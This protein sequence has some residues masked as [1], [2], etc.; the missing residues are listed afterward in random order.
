M[1]TTPMDRMHPAC[2]DRSPART[3]RPWPAR[4]TSAVAAGLLI[5][6]LALAA[7]SKAD[8]GSA[9]VGAAP[10]QAQGQAVSADSDTVELVDTA[11]TTPA[12]LT[13][14]DVRADGP[15]GDRRGLRVRL[16]RALHATW[17]TEGANGP[18]THQA[19]RGEVTAASGTSVTVKA[20]DGVSMTFAVTG[21]TRVRARSNGRGSDATM[22]S[23]AVGAKA[24]V[25]G[26]GASNP[27]ARVVVFRSGTPSAAPSPS[28][29][30]S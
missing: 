11:L 26:T 14:E 2:S 3:S 23:V 30:A 28:P 24:L 13:S 8:S 20:K 29:S 6:W 5:A 7:C 10:G 19:I 25:V 16:M 12:V 27:T 1:T 4:S 22:A 18:V 9:I 21:D 17:V 15:S